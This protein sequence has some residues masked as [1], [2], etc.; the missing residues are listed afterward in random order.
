MKVLT[1]WKA[2]LLTHRQLGQIMITQKDLHQQLHYD[3]I[4]GLFV[5]KVSNSPRVK[6]GKVAGTIKGKTGYRLI[7]V[8]NTLYRANRLAWLYVYGNLP[9]GVIDH[10]NFNRDDNSILNLRD[11]SHAEN[12]KHRNPNKPSIYRP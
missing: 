9:N 2:T 10:I 6:I 4:T 1:H 8:N 5:W 11:I 3:K 7:R 12:M